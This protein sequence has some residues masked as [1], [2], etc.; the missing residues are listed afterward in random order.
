MF[1]TPY[2]SN[3]HQDESEYSLRSIYITE[4]NGAYDPD[5]WYDHPPFFMYA[6]A[7]VFLI[8]GND[9]LIARGLGIL[10]GLVT[11]IIF[12][13]IGWEWKNEQVGLLMAGVFACAPISVM[14]NRYAMIDNLLGVFLGLIILFTL[15]YEKS[16]D[17][18]YLYTVA[19]FIALAFNTK[20]TAII[21]APPFLYYFYEKDLFKRK[22]GWICVGLILL[23]VLPVLLFMIDYGFI[24]LHLGKTS[25][26]THES[27]G[28]MHPL[29][30]AF[31]LHFESLA[32]LLLRTGIALIPFYFGIRLFWKNRTVFSNM[33][34]IWVVS[35]IIFFLTMR[36]TGYHYDYNEFLPMIPIIGFGLLLHKKWFIPVFVG[37]MVVTVCLFSYAPDQQTEALVYLENRLESNDTIIALPYPE[38]AY[39][40]KDKDVMVYTYEDIGKINAS[41]VVASRRR[42]NRLDESDVEIKNYLENYTLVFESEFDYY[43]GYL[44]YKRN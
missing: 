2:F 30:L 13:F 41:W 22:E 32:T 43:I 35:S 34:L 29:L 3:Y 26:I 6:Q 11:I 38:V 20:H 40:L 33:I 39:H 44:I 16:G 15:K 1:N 9:W 21:L 37:L 31:A 36:V 8:F 27:W 5:K 12:F 4:N 14:L 42:I 17:Y 10:L 19:I 18:K 28:G 7:G 23:I 25:H 24:Q